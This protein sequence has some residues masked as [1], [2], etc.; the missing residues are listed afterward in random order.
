NFGH[1]TESISQSST[2]ISGAAKKAS[3]NFG[4]MAESVSQSSVEIASSA[5]QASGNFGYMTQDIHHA[6]RCFIVTCLSFT[7][8]TL[9]GLSA[10]V[11]Y[12]Q[13]SSCDRDKESMLC[14][15]PLKSIA[16]VAIVTGVVAI[17]MLMPNRVQV[18]QNNEILASNET[19]RVMDLPDQVLKED[20]DLS[21]L[22]PEEGIDQDIKWTQEQLNSIKATNF[23]VFNFIEAKIKF[24]S[25]KWTKQELEWLLIQDENIFF[26]VIVSRVQASSVQVQLKEGKGLSFLIPEEGIDQDIEWTKEQLDLI[27]A[28]N[29]SV[30]NFIEAKIKFKCCKWTKQE[31]EWLLIQDENIFFN[32]IITRVQA[33]SDDL[34]KRN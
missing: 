7:T 5:N 25:C 1:M 20:M 21:F 19:T 9:V 15:V 2:E 14:T 8:S 26:N 11:T 30:F 29:F 32:M 31:L 24:K 12:F 6:S 16:A 33:T 4:H 10:S 28:T 22:I 17:R 34:D 18:H 3:Q 23:A 27:K 13:D